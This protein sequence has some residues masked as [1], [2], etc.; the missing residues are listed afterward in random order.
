MGL[1]VDGV[2][3]DRWYDTAS[4]G[5]RFERKASAYRNWIT[6]DGAPGPSGQGGFAAEAGRYH[7]YVS[8]ACPWAHR[9][10]IVRALKGLE[11]AISVSVVDP[12]MG[13]EGW[14]FGDTPG[15]TPD[16]LG[17]ATRLYEVYL[18]ADPAYTGRV[19]VPMLWDKAR[20]TI[21]SNESAEIIRMLN[22][23]FGGGGPDLYPA[24]L[25]A[26]ID[27][28]NA[29]VY[30]RVNNGVYKAG[31]AT[32]QAAYAEA[33]TA[34]FAELDALET[35]L[36]RTR[37]LCGDRLTEADVRLFTTLVR[38]DAVYV[39]HFKCN[40]RRIADSP[41]LSH[42]L[43]DLYALPGVAGT[44][45]LTHIKRHYYESHPTINPT[46]IVPLGPE[47]D[48]GA[49]NDRALRFGS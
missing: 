10:L 23:A 8:L 15:G 30:E 6:A 4:T 38:F 12:H 29:T 27:A 37:Y 26:A 16:H 28:V 3:Q 19:T 42:Y 39:G 2:W 32:E 9:T 46:R 31:F 41:N 47:I 11:A 17:N 5:G 25:R 40:L 13:E 34:L 33:F 43:R 35:R 18:R 21:V 20:G 24:D 1:L 44:V 7:L 45:N 22:G 48:L 14:V 49:A 36:D